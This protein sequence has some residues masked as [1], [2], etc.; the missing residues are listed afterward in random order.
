MM[1]N[2]LRFCE[3]IM[4]SEKEAL[5]KVFLMIKSNVLTYTGNN[6]RRIMILLGENDISEL[7]S[8]CVKGN[9]VYNP[10]PEADTWRIS[11]LDELLEVREGKYEIEGFENHELKEILEFVC[12]S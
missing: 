3:L 4:K 8:K 5:K 2:F 9:V 7:D 1:K 6:L 11:I 12:V 10:L